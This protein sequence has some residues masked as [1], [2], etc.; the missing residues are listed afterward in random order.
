MNLDSELMELKADPMF[1]NTKGS[2]TIA[3][4]L[5]DNEGEKSISRVGE[6]KMLNNGGKSDIAIAKAVAG[7]KGTLT[8]VGLLELEEQAPA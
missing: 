2:R 1:I 6:M 4:K 8:E 5:L 3:V 7:G